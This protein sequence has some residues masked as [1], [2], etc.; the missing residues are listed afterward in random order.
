MT[1]FY[2]NFYEYFWRQFLMAIFV[3]FETLI[4]ILIIE[5]LNSWQFNDVNKSDTGQHSQF[6][7]CFSQFSSFFGA[8]ITLKAQNYFSYEKCPETVKI[9]KTKSFPNQILQYVMQ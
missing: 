4:T 8:K 9:E 1:I 6:L 2:D 7:Q 5:N 3:T